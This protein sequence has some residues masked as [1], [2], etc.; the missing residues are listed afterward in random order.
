MKNFEVR[1]FK[2]SDVLD[3]IEIIKK[4]LLIENI[5]DYTC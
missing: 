1:R 5:K 4:D 2:D 3:V